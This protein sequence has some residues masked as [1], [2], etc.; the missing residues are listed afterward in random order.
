MKNAIEMKDITKCFPGVIANN[1]VNLC[2]KE[3]EI[4]CLLGENGSGKSTLMNILFGIHK[5]D[6]GEI[7]I[8]GK[9]VNIKSPKDANNLGIGMVHQH[10]MLFNQN[11]VLE[12]I[13]IGEERTRL[14]LNYEKS[15]KEIQSLID[16][17]SFNLNL[18]DKICN[19][20][21]GLKQRVEILK[22]LY[23]GVDII[24]FDE[25]TAVL[26]PQ[27][28]DML[29]DIILNL[30]DS[31]KTIIFISHKLGETMKIGDKITVLR[32]GNVAAT[33][34]CDKTSPEEL[35]RYMVG[36]D[37]ETDL[38]RSDY[39]PGDDVLSLMDVPLM[40]GKTPCNLSVR[41]GEILGIA[42]VDGNGQL[43]LEKLIMGIDN[44]TDGKIVFDS[45]DI[46]KMPT[47]DRKMNGI[48][49]IPSDRYE[50]AMVPTESILMNLLLGNHE[51]KKFVKHGIVNLKEM[52]NYS[53]KMVEE[54]NVKISDINQPIQTLSGGNQQKVILSRE[55][56]QSPKLILA[57]Q[58]TRGLDIGAIEFVHKLLL[59]KRDEG[60]AIILISAELSEITT[61]SD[62]IAVLY[63][64]EVAACDFAENFTRDEL[65]LL[66]AGKK[67][68]DH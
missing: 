7:F 48:A 32:K 49:Y 37:I 12:N 33:I 6:S 14:L 9:K 2:V 40:Q 66:M 36:K 30:R 54:Y 51:R 3:Q 27:E 24:I 34:D 68:D 13:I 59:K 29:M 55:I 5:Q 22:I 60:C 67:G 42:G 57:A 35:A 16:K 41:A 53:M 17:Y 64:G 26:T 50:F 44:I 46:T 63:E 31:G 18:D 1:S 56:S 25:P 58:P 8:K 21:I 62:R 10:F 47:I 45:I 39:Y 23:R 11:T 52:T 61:L 38:E 65:G 43:E 15:K 20:S 28:S 19:L 4:H